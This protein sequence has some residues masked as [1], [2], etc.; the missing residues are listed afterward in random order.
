M[1]KIAECREMAGIKQCLLVAEL[2]WT[3]T[4]VSNYEAG[5]RTAGLAECRAIVAALNRLGAACSLDDVFP[6]K[7]DAP[8][9]A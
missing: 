2:G 7:C 1:N 8:K 9:A 5:R 6:P 4:R 3:Q